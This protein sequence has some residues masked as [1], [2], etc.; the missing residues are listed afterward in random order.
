MKI[1]IVSDTHGQPEALG[2]LK[3]DLLIHCGD[4]CYDQSR[5]HEDLESL[6]RWF[7]RQEFRLIVCTGGNHDFLVEERTTR[8]KQPFRHAVC[9]Q[10]SGASLDGVKIYGAPWVPE[11]SHWAHY[12][13]DGALAE[14]WALIPEDTD[15]LVTHTPPF[16]TLDTNSRGRQC[17]CRELQWRLDELRP[18]VHCFGHIHA[19]ADSM[20]RS[21][22]TYVNASLVDRSYKLARPPVTLDVH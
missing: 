11:L 1:T 8:T 5:A 12:R 6:N 9:L 14:A 18:R 22:T 13:S 10:D 17:G 4:F 16:G 2:E 3:G 19:S 20:E 21:G 7:S 15:I